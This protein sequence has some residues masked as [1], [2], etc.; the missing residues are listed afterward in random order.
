MAAVHSAYKWTPLG[1]AQITNLAAAVG[2]PSV[3]TDT[4]MVL[5]EAEAQAVRWRDDGTN[6][7]AAIG[8]PLAAGQE[9]QYTVV[10]LT[11][12]KFI[13]QVGGAILNVSYYK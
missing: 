7:T 9:F 13:Q 8:M 3:P 5:I 1:Y 4:I 10:D 2:L 12:I 11:Q 6:P